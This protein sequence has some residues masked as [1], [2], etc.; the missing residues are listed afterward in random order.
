MP[1]EP[2]VIDHRG[3]HDSPGRAADREALRKL[4]Q[5]MDSA[6]EVPGLGLRFGLDSLVGLFPGVGDATTSLVSLY[7]LQAAVRHNVSRVALARMGLNI[8]LDWLLG[9]IPFLGDVFDL[10]WKA[11]LRN[12]ALLE[13]HLD[14]NPN[15]QRRARRSDWLF[16]G[17]LFFALLLAFVGS[18]TITILL[19]ATLLSWWQ[20]GG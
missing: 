3:L 10:Y 9:S 2:E 15:Q 18:V 4:S 5:W 20:R 11:N 14:A 16:L 17:G 8:A 12:V 19:T 1:V 7:I 13:K 6:F